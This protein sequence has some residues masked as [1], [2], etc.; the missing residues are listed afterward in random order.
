MNASCL[1]SIERAP[2]AAG[3]SAVQH[4]L[5]DRRE[6]GLDLEARRLRGAADDGRQ[7]ELVANVLAQAAIGLELRLG[8]E[9]VGGRNVREV[10]L[11]EPVAAQELALVAGERELGV[12]EIAVRR[13]A[14][15]RVLGIDD[16]AEAEMR[17]AH[18]LR[19]QP[20]V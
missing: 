5:A 3:R 20:Q 8:E 9:L 7:E 17:A 13:R 12:E 1:I 4:A 18:A 19:S 11:V 6:P 15:A 16:A 10:R 14:V 2:R